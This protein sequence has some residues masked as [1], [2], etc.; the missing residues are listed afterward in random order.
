MTIISP[1]PSSLGFSSVRLERW[2]ESGTFDIAEPDPAD[3]S[4]ETPSGSLWLPP[5]NGSLSIART[6]VTDSGGRHRGLVEFRDAAGAEV[7]GPDSDRLVAVFSLFP[8]VH[9]RV[10][11]LVRALP[12]A[13]SGP[14]RVVPNRWALRMDFPTTSSDLLAL[15]PDSP[16]LADI[17]FDDELR[18]LPRPMTRGRRTSI[19][20]RQGLIRIPSGMTARMYCFDERGLPTDPGMVAALW[21]ALAAEFD[22]LAED[23]LLLAP[24]AGRRVHCVGLAEGPLDDA[25]LGLIQV[26]GATATAPVMNFRTATGRSP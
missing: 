11:Q 17:G 22:G 12:G 21:L 16:T 4:V 6:R 3:L 9:E 25:T 26:G 10:K 2:F 13:T 23:D 8:L 14:S 19:G 5:A 18:P 24:Q 1:D 7:F 15:V 20:D